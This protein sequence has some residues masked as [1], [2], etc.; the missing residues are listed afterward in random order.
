MRV[1]VTEL[2]ERLNTTWD[3]AN[4]IIKLLQSNKLACRVDFTKKGNARPTAIWD[5]ADCVIL[6]LQRGVVECSNSDS[7]NKPQ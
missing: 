5:I 4:G 6:D 2:S 1:T 3:V 7:I